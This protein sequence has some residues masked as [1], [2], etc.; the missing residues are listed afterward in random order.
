[1]LHGIPAYYH[2]RARFERRVSLITIGVA[3]GMLGALWLVS[4]PEVRRLLPLDAQ[5][6]GFE[7]REQYVRRI[8]LESLGPLNLQS[9][10]A[11]TLL[12]Q[13]AMKGGVER[14]VRTRAT[15]AEPETRE[16]RM[17]PGVSA[18]DLIARA[19]AIYR[20]APVIQSED[21]IIEHLVKPEYPEDARSRNIEGKVALV[22]LVDT[23]GH[24]AEVDILGS[25][26]ERQLE[27]AAT[28]AVW[29]CQFRPYRVKGE[30]REVY[31]V[32]R[33]AFRIY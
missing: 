9:G 11:L 30:V 19:R 15:L 24:V 4:R 31:A 12:R 5:R 28:Q 6:F 33:F 10:P 16:R 21:L 20:T 7:G 22:A 14:P 23:T 3:F 29:Q 18:E 27:K 17:G 25:S 8:I 32:F 2:E 13:S 26:G 1:M